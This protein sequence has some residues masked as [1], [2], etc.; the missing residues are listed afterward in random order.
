M[1]SMRRISSSTVLRT[2]FMTNRGARSKTGDVSR[3]HQGKVALVTGSSDT[4]GIGFA[5]ARSLAKR[6]CSIILSGIRD[7]DEMDSLRTE[8]EG[9]YEVPAHYIKA[10]LNV[11]AA[12]NTLYDNVRHI[13]AEGVDIL[14]NNAAILSIHPMEEFPLET[15]ERDLRVNLTAPFYLTKLCLPNMKRKG[16]GRIVNISS[17]C[18]VRGSVQLASYCS[19]KHGLHG[20]TKVTA[21]ETLG[22]GVTSNAI[23]PGL[24][25]TVMVREMIQTNAENWG[26]SLEE[27]KKRSVETY[28]LSG[29]LVEVDQIGELSAFL[30]SPAADQMTGSVYSID[31]GFTAQ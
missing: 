15:W 25:D 2:L 11:L 24:T 20:L 13:Y 6:G 26:V 9:Q 4:G 5:I 19:A 18:G 3:I 22:S 10:D 17:L 21:L 1:Y 16:W 30:C 28:S 27:A 29:Q 8:L 12:I 23:A 31:A 14:V 7:S